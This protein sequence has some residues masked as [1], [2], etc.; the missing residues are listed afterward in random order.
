MAAISF[1]YFIGSYIGGILYDIFGIKILYLLGLGTCI[2]GLILTIRMRN[3]RQ[4]EENVKEN[5]ES[6]I[7]D[8]TPSSHNLISTLKDSKLV[9]IIFIIAIIQT[10]QASFSGI[11]GSYSLIQ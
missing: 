1:G 5:L 3:I 6:N 4:S 7:N 2:I 9:V 8:L 10:F 11:F